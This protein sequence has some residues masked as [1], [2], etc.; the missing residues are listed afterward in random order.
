[1]DR[2]PAARPKLFLTLLVLL[3]LAG[4]GL[5][6]HALG[7]KALWL[8]EVFT[9]VRTD[10]AGALEILQRVRANERHPPL[11]HLLSAPLLRPGHGDA[12]VRIL[13]ALASTLTVLMAGLLGR[14]LFGPTA[15][16]VAALLL[17]LSAFEVTVAQEGRPAALATLL[18]LAS[19]F[20]FHRAVFGPRGRKALPVLA[21]Y[22][23]L[24]ALALHTYYYAAFLLAAQL[25]FLPILGLMRGRE[26]RY[27]QRCCWPAAAAG[28]VGILLF[29][30]WA[31][32]ARESL[33]RF[34]S[35]AAG[36]ESVNY[37]LV[38]VVDFFRTLAVHPLKFSIGWL[39]L[40]L[41]ILVLALLAAGL[42]LWPRR[43]RQDLVLAGLLLLLPLLGVMASPFKPE[44]FQPKHLAFL[45]PV[46]I[47]LLARLLSRIRPRWATL[48]PA[49]LIIGLNIFSLTLY[50]GDG[51]H[52]TAVRECTAAIATS[53][54]PGD[55]ILFNPAFASGSFERYEAGTPLPK[56]IVYPNRFDTLR[57]ELLRHRRVWL[58]EYR[59]A[60]FGP[61]PSYN[62][63]VRR[64][65]RP[66]GGQRTFAG[67]NEAITVSL[68]H[69]LAAGRSRPEPS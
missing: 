11:F 9:L 44:I 52:K 16:L 48:V 8:D 17:A 1:M 20:A 68:H 46:F 58:V 65:L 7:D 6:F 63:T 5:R 14:R 26:G 66:I 51:Y 57:G 43:D 22:G 45:S 62:A 18:L 27:L 69:H 28:A 64:A 21:A 67:V 3:V 29:L 31:F 25:L 61:L 24:T 36:K 39:N 4:A 10:D 49:V 53:V 37:G 13:P 19:T 60:T 41:A 12:A 33:Q 40:A 35:M 56:I 23:L 47:I 55:A 30:P 59:G 15:G 54:R 32:S 50:Y 42:L 2:N 34:S 38:T